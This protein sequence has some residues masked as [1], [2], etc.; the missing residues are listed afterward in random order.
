MTLAC[1]FEVGRIE[2]FTKVS[3]T[4]ACFV[5]CFY[6]YVAHV[7]PCM[8]HRPSAMKRDAHLSKRPIGQLL[9]AH[10]QHQTKLR[11]VHEF[12]ACV[13]RSW[14]RGTDRMQML[15]NKH[16]LPQLGSVMAFDGAKDWLSTAMCR[17]G[18]SAISC[19]PII[20]CRQT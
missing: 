6:K 20:C 5:F 14:Q 2:G 13:R 17:V 8:V 19:W 15:K 1:N 12:N 4:S 10:H 16:Q 18:V 7:N 11:F 3:E 9:H